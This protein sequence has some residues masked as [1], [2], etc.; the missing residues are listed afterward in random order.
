M[1]Q[2]I[3]N[4][5]QENGQFIIF[6]IM[7]LEGLNLTGIPAIVILP[8]VGILAAEGPAHIGTI[9]GITILGS[10]IGN[11]IYYLIVR[12]IGGRVYDFFYNKFKGLRKSL[13]K[14]DKLIE[15]YGDKACC[16]G[17]LIPGARTVISLI[18]GTFRV[19]FMKFILYSSVGI[20][21]WD[22]VLVMA[23]YLFNMG[24]K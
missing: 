4:Y 9:L 16:I 24:G 15:Q 13:D 8:A 19:N 21:I 12:I 11:V 22:S 1:A 3:L 14:A 2:T 7:V 23:G 5:I 18:A 17:R 20:I 6:V 10:I